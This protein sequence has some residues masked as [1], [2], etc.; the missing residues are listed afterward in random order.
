MCNRCTGKI[1]KKSD[2]KD[3]NVAKHEWSYSKL[4]KDKKYTCVC[5]CESGNCI[6]FVHKRTGEEIIVGRQ[7]ILNDM[8]EKTDPI[9]DEVRHER[10]EE[11]NRRYKYNSIDAHLKS[12]KHLNRIKAIT[13][14]ALKQKHRQEM[15]EKFRTCKHCYDYKIPINDPPIKL[16]C[17]DCVPYCVLK[18]VKCP[19]CEYY[20][21]RK[22][23]EQFE[24]CYNCKVTQT[25]NIPGKKRFNMIYPK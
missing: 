18:S 1:I 21:T 14:E 10:C 2:S 19:R 3:W 8:Y 16:Y 22:Q 23:S 15:E 24:V 13:Q 9:I 11:C 7:C 5:G 25:S 17:L 20:I 6:L 4:G 12:N